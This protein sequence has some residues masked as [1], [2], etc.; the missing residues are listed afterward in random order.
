MQVQYWIGP[1][2]REGIHLAHYSDNNSVMGQQGCGF[3]LVPHTQ[4][5]DKGLAKLWQVVFAHASVAI[6]V[7]GYLV[8][9]MTD[10][11]PVTMYKLI[12]YRYALVSPGR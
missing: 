4:T 8:A 12:T 1:I 5:G 10:R 6:A 2:D 7:P 9:R 3:Y 11:Y